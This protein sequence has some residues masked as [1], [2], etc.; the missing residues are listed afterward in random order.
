MSTTTTN[1]N[2]LL[3]RSV[4]VESALTQFF[5]LPPCYP[6]E[7][8]LLTRALCGIVF[9][10]AESVKVLTSLGNFTSAAGL[11]RL[12]YETLVRALWIF[13]TASDEAVGSLRSELTPENAKKADKLPMLSEMLKHL[14]GKC[15]KI[16]TDQ[17]LEFKEYSWKPLSSY[18]HGGL[19][20]IHRHTKGYPLELLIQTVKTSNGVLFMSGTLMAILSGDLRQQSI[21]EKFYNDYADCMPPKR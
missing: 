14:E 16:L 15:P 21:I 7:R 2:T 19:H 11:V 5:A 1:L 4:E 6:S 9:E 20:A 3:A 13:Y 10:H 8:L 18:V 17:L 12:Q